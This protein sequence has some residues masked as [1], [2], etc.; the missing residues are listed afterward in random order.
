MSQHFYAFGQQIFLF[1]YR[2]CPRF[3]KLAWK[4]LSY[5]RHP[6][7][8]RRVRVT[9]TLIGVD[10]RAWGFKHCCV[11]ASIGYRSQ[12]WWSLQM[13]PRHLD[14]AKW[15]SYSSRGFRFRSF[16]L[17]FVWAIVPFTY[18]LRHRRILWKQDTFVLLKWN[19]WLDQTVL[20]N[21]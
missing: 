11:T 16:A 3:W 15:I 2:F 12:T 9:P 8:S 7:L 19:V 10:S 5:R 6:F 13:K 14:T 17:S 1:L 4:A 20:I 18:A 21:F